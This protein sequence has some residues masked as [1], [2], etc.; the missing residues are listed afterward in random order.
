MDMYG[1]PRYSE[2][3]PTAFVAVTYTL[4]FG[5]MFGDLGQGLLVAR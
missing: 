5:V 1:L 3:D 2:I 4:L